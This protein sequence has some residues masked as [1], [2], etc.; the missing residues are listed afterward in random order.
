MKDR[1]I[2]GVFKYLASQPFYV[3]VSLD[4]YIYFIISQIVFLS[5][6]VGLAGDEVAISQKS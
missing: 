3:N 5:S 6:F 4:V 2:H 1:N